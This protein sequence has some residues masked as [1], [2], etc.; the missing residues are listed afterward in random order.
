[1][2]IF[3]I[4]TM[5]VGSCLSWSKTDDNDIIGAHRMHQ[6]FTRS[7]RDIYM[8]RP[9]MPLGETPSHY[10]NRAFSIIAGNGK[11]TPRSHEPGAD[12]LH[13]I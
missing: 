9:R 11:Q 10:M 2:I 12:G 4:N 13:E 7:V 8:T 1:M 5:V 3:E 6:M